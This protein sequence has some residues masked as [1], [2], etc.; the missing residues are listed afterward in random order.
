MKKKIGCILG[1]LLVFSLSAQIGNSAKAKE[2][3]SKLTL[4]EKADL[5]VG[6]GMKIPGMNSQS[7]PVVGKTEDKVP[8]AAG[9]THEFPRLGIPSMVLSDGPAGLRINPSRNG[10]SSKT[11]YATAW[12]VATLLASTWDTGMVK[13]TS[14]S[15]TNELS[16]YEDSIILGPAQ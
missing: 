10:D 16:D 15:V 3:V 11:F 7:G 2:I 13:R 8:G 14:A 9:T 1:V 6:K 4:E 5:V 12:P